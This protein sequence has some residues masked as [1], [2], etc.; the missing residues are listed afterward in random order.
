[1]RRGE[2]LLEMQKIDRSSKLSL[3]RYGENNTMRMR[4]DSEKLGERGQT[5]GLTYLEDVKMSKK[6]F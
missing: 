4:K 2:T 3:G 6:L 5:F 1:M